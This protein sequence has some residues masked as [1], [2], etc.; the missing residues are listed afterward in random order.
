[1]SIGSKPA[2]VQ[3]DVVRGDTSTLRVEFFEQDQ[4]NPYDTDNW[5][6]ICTVYNR[7]DQQFY[8]LDVE[9]GDGF[10]TIVADPEVTFLWGEGIKSIVA[11]LDFD[12]EVT[13]EDGV[14]WTPVIGRISVI[15]DISGRE[16]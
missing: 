14:V 1:M 10:V 13:M 9:E 3:W 16:E 6:Y 12:L 8:I 4:S 5:S 2:Y 15:G 7:Q 11:Q